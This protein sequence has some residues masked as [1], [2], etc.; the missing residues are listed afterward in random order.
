MGVLLLLYYFMK[1]VT[2]VSFCLFVHCVCTYIRL[3]LLCC[4]S[5]SPTQCCV[6]ARGFELPHHI[7]RHDHLRYGEEVGRQLSV[8]QALSNGPGE[9]SPWFSSSMVYFSSVR[10]ECVSL[11]VVAPVYS[12]Q[13]PCPQIAL[14]QH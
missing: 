3:L 13:L 4:L 8:A 14:T 12:S 11:L 10:T 2:P 7:D 5:L 1:E 6:L 9:T